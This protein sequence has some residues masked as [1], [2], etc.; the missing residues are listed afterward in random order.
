MP[1][2]HQALRRFFAGHR[3]SADTSLALSDGYVAQVASGGAEC[4]RQRSTDGV[5]GLIIY[6]SEIQRMNAELPED[7]RLTAIYPTE[8]TMVAEYRL[9]LLTGATAAEQRTFDT[10]WQW[11]FSEPVQKRIREATGRRPGNPAVVSAQ[12][13]IPVP[14]LRYPTDPKALS[15]LID[16]Y[17]AQI[18]T[19]SRMVFVLDVSGSMEQNMSQL[20][21][22]LINLTGTDENDPATYFNFLPGE[23]VDFVPFSNGAQTPREFTLP[24]AETGPTLTAIQD[25]ARKDLKAAGYTAMY[26]ALQSAHALVRPW[27][28]EAD[29]GASTSIV[30]FSDGQNTCGANYSQYLDF[31]AGLSER[32]RAVP[33][34]T[35]AFDSGD[36]S[37]TPCDRYTPD[38][39]PASVAGATQWERELRA[40]AEQSGG[41]LFTA[42]RDIPLYTVFWSIRGYQ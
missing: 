40:V 35:I 11:L 6:E 5:D 17:R 13:A 27:L 23:R 24:D 28:A 32:E 19:P 21:N 15:R 31:R 12:N 1:G 41:Q 14:Q 22:A 18:R 26:D 2:L 30:L 34:Y 39:G 8:G 42:G 33:I 25:Y 9:S 16:A 20:R 36:Q 10:L 37:T 7:C 29:D 3:L 4:G 38:P